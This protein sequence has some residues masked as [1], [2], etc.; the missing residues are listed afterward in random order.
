MMGGKGNVIGMVAGIFVM[1]MIGTGMQLAGW[2]SYTQYIVKGLILLGA[3]TFDA[4]KSRPKPVVRVHE[5]K[6]EEK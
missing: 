5:E 4:L 1:Q 2:G 6:K 3:I